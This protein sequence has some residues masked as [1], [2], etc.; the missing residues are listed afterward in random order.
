[1]KHKSLGSAAADLNSHART[2]AVKTYPKSWYYFCAAIFLCYCYAA[3]APTGPVW[4]IHFIAY[5]PTGLKI[6]LLAVSGVM[7]AP[8]VQRSISKTASKLVVWRTGQSERLIQPALIALGC[9]VGFHLFTIKTDAYG[10][11]INMVRWYGDNASFNWRWI[12]DVLSFDWVTNK[13]AL[14]VGLHRTVS[15]IFSIPIGSA[16]RIMSELCGTVF[17]FVWLVYVQKIS[18]GLLRLVLSLLGLFTGG[19]QVFFG[20]IENYPFAILTFTVF[21]SAFFFYLESKVRTPVLLV[22]YLL[23]VK[24][25]IIGVLFLPGLVLGIL[26]RFRESIPQFE[27]RFTW[28]AIFL[29]VILPTCLLGIVSYFFV[30]HSW[31]EPYALRSGRQFQQTF[32][33]IVSPAAPLN[34]YTL[35]SPY[36]IADFLNV[37]MLI[38]GPIVLLL[39]A[40]FIFNRR[41]VVWSCPIVIVFG[42]IALFPF[43]FF[44]AM[45]PTLSPVRDWDVYTL[46]LPPLLFFVASIMTHSTVRDYVP[47]WLAVPLVFG[48]LFSVAQMGVE[49]SPTALSH[50]LRDAGIYTYKSYYAGASFIETRALAARTKSGLPKKFPEMVNELSK[51]ATP[52]NDGEL[53]NMMARASYFYSL[54]GDRNAAVEW[55]EKALHWDTANTRYAY[56][57]AVSYLQVQEVTKA[58]KIAENLLSRVGI[59]DTANLDLPRLANLMAQLSKHYQDIG[60]DSLAIRWADAAHRMDPSNLQY[61]YDLVNTYLQTKRVRQALTVLQTIPQDSL[62]LDMVTDMALA[63]GQIYGIDSALPYFNKARSMAPSSHAVDTLLL[64]I[65]AAIRR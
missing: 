23:A 61:T 33:P 56:N 31:N 36:H 9:F 45:N 41:Q 25:H 18:T 6:A 38:A 4:G 21:L 7:L 12:T 51:H 28:R 65:E 47:S 26:Y 44:L 40:L 8:S 2:P 14:T 52:G 39:V 55:G 27:T 57:L 32:L 63:A 59:H 17:V 50:R 20:H 37:V 10:D 30:F 62:S 58:E 19:L 16:Y 15:Y 13:E 29:S 53:A 49:A 3:F 34:H 54:Q 24:A 5:L 42:N 35:W 22:L 1:M 11:S 64:Q 43:L 46:L 60:I 48:M